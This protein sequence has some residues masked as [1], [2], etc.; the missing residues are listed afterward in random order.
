MPR[1][2]TAIIIP[3]FNEERSVPGVVAELRAFD[4]SLRTVV[5]DDGSTDNTAGVARA[6]GS[7]VQLPVNLGIGGAVQTGIRYAAR[8]DFH[9]CLQVDGDGQHIAAEI[10]ALRRAQAETG[11]NLVI[12]S[13][14]LAQGGFQSTAMR[15]VGIRVIAA[16]LRVFFG[17]QVTDPTSG[18][19]LMDREAIKLFARTYP[20]DFPE[21]VSIALAVEHGLRV[22]EVGV[23]MRERAHGTSSLSGLRSASYMFRVLGYLVL[24]RLKRLL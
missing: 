8:N 16:A 10:A 2:S 1:T 20:Q 17:V 13:R 24:L 21:P 6:M 22:S 15:R 12:G 11:A 7:V 14:F 5:I 19:R 18:F 3:C 4:P 23:A 9:A